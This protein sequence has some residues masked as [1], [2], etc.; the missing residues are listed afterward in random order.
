MS[1][2]YSRE[3]TE[4][5][6]ALVTNH[7]FFASLLYMV[8]KVK[9]DDAT[10]TA[11]TDGRTIYVG[12][13]FG[14]LDIK[15]RVFVLAHEVMHVVFE[16]L[17][18]A[19]LYRDRGFGPDLNPWNDKKFNAAA[20]YY[21]NNLLKVGEVGEMP[22]AGLWNPQICG[23]DAT[24]A[25][26]IYLSLPDDQEDENFDEH[27]EPKGGE[28][29]GEGDGSGL[30]DGPPTTSEVQR[31]VVAS[32]NAAKALGK[33]PS[34]MSR[35]LGEI[36]DPVQ[37][38][39]DILRDLITSTVGKEEMSWRRPNRRRLVLPPYVLFP[40]SEGFAMGTMVVAVDTSGSISQKELDAF[41]GEMKGILEEVRPRELWV[42]WWD[43]GAKLVRIE[44]MEDLNDPDKAP[45]GGGGTD[46][47]CVEPALQDEFLD[48]EV[49][50]CLTD[51]MV[52]WPSDFPWEHITVT[53][54][55]SYK[56]PFGRNIYMDVNFDR[57]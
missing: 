22:P 37:P 26:K 31:A 12:K 5:L 25:D 14:E 33:M 38:W 7:P 9:E 6:S 28:D 27:M 49:V 55:E 43:T 35:A 4:A 53:T 56:C 23:T 51:G 20:D 2:H 1:R 17:P 41:L 57:V 29:E 32:T 50:V 40:G 24:T 8:M 48:P 21:I 19:K 46:Y 45:C 36:L 15:Q 13:W 44:D 18:R 54:S 3:V 52:H 34:G 39:K 11:A 47:T 16:H 42:C 10:P 30:P